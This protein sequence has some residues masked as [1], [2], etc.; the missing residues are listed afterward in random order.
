[1]NSLVVW[2]PFGFCQTNAGRAERLQR[3]RTR[4][5]LGLGFGIRNFGVKKG[6]DILTSNTYIL[7][8]AHVWKRKR[9]TIHPQS[10]LFDRDSTTNGLV[11][12]LFW[13]LGLLA[14]G[15]YGV[16]CTVCRAQ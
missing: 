14:F 9:P 2:V 12:G 6:Q 15:H 16:F 13:A 1:M 5:W 8:S 11:L 10:Q 4:S 7:S 3:T